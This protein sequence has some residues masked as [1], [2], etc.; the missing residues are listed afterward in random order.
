MKFKS[1]NF[2]LIVLILYLLLEFTGDS[3]ELVGNKLKR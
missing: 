1:I 3:F 2:D